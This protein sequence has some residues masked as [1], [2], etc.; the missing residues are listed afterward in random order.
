VNIRG[1]SRLT[2]RNPVIGGRER[3]RPRQPSRLSA[4]PRRCSHAQKS[5]RRA[6]FALAAFFAVA[7]HS[8]LAHGPNQPPH[9]LYRIGDLKLESGETIRDFSIS[10]VTHG[11]LNAKKS[12]A[13]LMVT[14]ISG[15]HHRLDFLIGP[16][17]ALDTDKYFIV[18]TDAIG[19]GLT[20]SPSNSTVQ[21]HM[22][23]PHFLIRDM[24]TSQYKLMTEH[25]GIQHVVTVIGPSMGGM[26]TLQ[27]GV[28]Y[29]DFMDS[30]VAMVPLA[31]TPAWTVT[32]LEA[33]RKAIMLDS[34]WKGGDY[35]EPPE[36]GIR[37]WRDII[38]FLAART[39]EL[40][41]DQ[42][43]NQLD[44]LPW[45]REQET[46]LIKAFDAN[47]WIYQTW[48]YDQHDVGTTPGMNGDLVKA[49]RTIKAK[50][51]IMVGT[52]DLL[53]PEWEPRE[54]ARYIRDVRVST[55]SPGTVTGHAS[56]GGASPADVDFLNGEI[57]GFLDVVTQ[58]GKRLE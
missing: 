3:P 46:G 6:T 42:F 40:S 57:V 4:A 55:I 16:G 12:N 54:A 9:Q 15:N 30:M 20:T 37:L 27:W 13:I 31:R 5:H 29:P 56:A 34:A 36:Q 32:V 10:Y 19:N 26:Q 38:S 41:R 39:P 18:C 7:A 51:L 58:K 23:F 52:K 2:G 47:D 22:K 48:A 50:T 33:T 1:I 17:K 11:K 14:A 35:A 49:L 8:A 43:P 53:N 45:I 28:S 25:L 21:P 44:I 24:V